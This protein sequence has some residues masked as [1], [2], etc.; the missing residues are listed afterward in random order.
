ME[1]DVRISFRPGDGNKDED[2]GSEEYIASMV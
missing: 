2:S 1:G